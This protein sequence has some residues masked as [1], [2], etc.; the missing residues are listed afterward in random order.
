MAVKPNGWA[1]CLQEKMGLLCAFNTRFRVRR[2]SRCETWTYI[3]NMPCQQHNFNFSVKR[4]HNGLQHLLTTQELYHNYTL[5]LP[6]LVMFV[7]S[8]MSFDSSNKHI[9]SNG[10]F[11]CWLECIIDFIAAERLQSLK[12]FAI[13][14]AVAAFMDCIKCTS[15][16]LY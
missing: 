7:V 15:E 14:H 5:S 1:C 11:G 9:K 12:N 3:K 6:V 13:H 16:Q 4:S 8:I 10:P 2:G